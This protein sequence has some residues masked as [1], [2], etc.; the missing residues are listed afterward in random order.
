VPHARDKR[1]H[2]RR[3]NAHFDGRFK[4]STQHLTWPAERKEGRRCEKGVGHCLGL[5]M[6]APGGEG[7]VW[8]AAKRSGTKRAPAGSPRITS[9]ECAKRRDSKA[10]ASRSAAH[11]AP[12]PNQ[13][14]AGYFQ[15][16]ALFKKEKVR[17]RRLLAA[18]FGHELIN[19]WA[20]RRFQPHE[21]INSC[22][23]TRS[24]AAAGS[25]V[26]PTA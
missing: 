3:N 13:S 14:R 21:L 4:G 9:H 26:A 18:A 8:P 20:I 5:V 15:A 25:R 16:N 6:G 11:L 24:G 2:Y 22:G 12:G 10:G 7:S 1:H 23:I 19:W 17:R